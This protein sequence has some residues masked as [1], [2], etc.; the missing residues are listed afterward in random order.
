[1]SASSH[2]HV[3]TA[4]PGYQNEW[5][6]HTVHWHGF[7]SLSSERDEYIPSPEFMLVGNQWYL[8]LYPGGDD[9][10]AEEMASLYL[11]N[12]SNKS[13]EVEYG[14]SVNDGNGK[15]V[16]YKQSPFTRNFAPVD[17]DDISRRDGQILRSAQ[18]Y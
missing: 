16:A 1:M 8:E 3:G 14:F 6:T 7:E 9:D 18:S 12:M 4:P 5:V 15:Q 2:T 10:A 13:I 11:E 17:T